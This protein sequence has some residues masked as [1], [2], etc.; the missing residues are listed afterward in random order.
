MNVKKVL[1][2][3]AVNV[4]LEIEKVIP[5]KLDKEWL[6]KVLG[7]PSFAFD[8]FT[9]TKAISEPIWDLLGR[10]GKRWRPTMMLASYQALGGKEETAKHF[11]PI[12]EVIHNGTLMVDDIEDNSD[13]RR[14]KPC[15]HKSFGIDI[16]VN[17][18]NAMYYLTTHLLYNNPYKLSEKSLLAIHNL[19]SLELTRLH[20][21]QG[22]DI[23]WHNGKKSDVKEEEY[24]QMCAY[25]TGTLA[26]LAA[27]LGGILAEAS[28]EKIEKIGLFAEN[29]AIAFQIQDDILNVKPSS[30]WTKE[31]GDDI[32]EGKRTLI[33]IHCLKNSNKEK[34]NRLLEILDLHTKD[35]NL[36]KEAIELMVETGSIDYA[37]K[38]AKELAVKGWKEIEGILKENEGKQLLKSLTDYLIER[39]I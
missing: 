27:K 5:R 33:V 17:A 15:T 29:T 23:V 24:L 35:E 32:N 12:V 19:I 20:F 8:E 16:A 39:E 11:Q 25:K 37:K 22:M 10:G 30:E 9:S 34:R 36:I 4:N 31:L 3:K 21:G 14:G 13:L 18:G 28:E 2:E 6:E 38:K 26:R 1:E 7:K